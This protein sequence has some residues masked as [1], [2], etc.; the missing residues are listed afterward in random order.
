MKLYLIAG[1]CVRAT[2]W[3]EAH[4]KYAAYLQGQ[5]ELQ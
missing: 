3:T 2:S 5:G 4:A 1:H